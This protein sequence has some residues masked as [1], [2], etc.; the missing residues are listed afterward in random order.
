MDA[1]VQWLQDRA[2]Q[3]WEKQSEKTELPSSGEMFSQM[4][5]GGLGRRRE[6]D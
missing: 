2:S 1:R 4:L 3:D 5:F 6:R